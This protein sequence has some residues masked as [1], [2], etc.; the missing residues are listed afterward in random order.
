MERLT[1]ADRPYAVAA[2]VAHDFN[3]ELTIILT[4]VTQSLEMLDDEHP[5]VDLLLDLQDAAQR[6]AWRAAGLLNFSARK[7]LLSAPIS[8]EHLL[9]QLL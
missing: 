9:E 7:G 2:A 4:A 3:N 1:Q 5:A 6:C 8:V